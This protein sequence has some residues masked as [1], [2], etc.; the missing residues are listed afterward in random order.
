MFSPL[1]ESHNSNKISKDLESQGDQK[2][3][4]DQQE[5]GR[6]TR[7]RKTTQDKNKKHE[8]CKSQ[9][10]FKSPRRLPNP[11]TPETQESGRLAN[12]KSQNPRG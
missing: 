9:E 2:S 11:K 8:A 3:P 6:L 12:S 4:E 5:S 7:V 10:I 1:K